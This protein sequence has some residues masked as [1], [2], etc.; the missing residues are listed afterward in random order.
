MYKELT[1][2]FRHPSSLGLGSVVAFAGIAFVLQFL[3]GQS[4][5]YLETSD[6]E[7]SSAFDYNHGAVDCPMAVSIPDEDAIAAPVGAGEYGVAFI[8][9]GW[10]RY[11]SDSE[12]SSC[13]SRYCAF[14][15][16]AGASDGSD[17]VSGGLIYDWLQCLYR[18]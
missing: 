8:E 6:L 9:A 2:I 3:V 13:E 4:V 5:P 18:G 1:M 10:T 11:G 7:S 16:Y 14:S 17:G 15:V 12:Y